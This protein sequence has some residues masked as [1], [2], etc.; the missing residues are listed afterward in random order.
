MGAKSFMIGLLRQTARF[1]CCVVKCKYE[2]RS[3][4]PKKKF[5]DHF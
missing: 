2:L 4:Q 3:V 1:S 5:I